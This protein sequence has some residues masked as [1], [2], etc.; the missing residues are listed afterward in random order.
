MAT[1]NGTGTLYWG[2]RH[3][4]DGTAIATRWFAIL[5]M[6]IIPLYRQRV[7]VL[8]NF[9]TGQPTH[10]A[11][12]G[13]VELTDYEDLGRLPLSF[14]EVAVTMAKTYL[15]LPLILLGPLAVT[16][17]FMLLVAKVSQ[18]LTGDRNVGNETIPMIFTGIAM[19][20]IFNFIWQCLL[21]IRAGKGWHPDALLRADPV[22]RCMRWIIAPLSKRANAGDSSGL[23]PE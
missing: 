3:S 18:V 9:E 4:A 16:G 19:L 5:W 21:A 14:S 6:P 2:W 12:L 7:R 11:G 22:R 17:L 1:I 13:V 8:T 20:A 10:P 15:G 23:H